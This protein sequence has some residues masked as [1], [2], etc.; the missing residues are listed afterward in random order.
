MTDENGGLEVLNQDQETKD[1]IAE[2]LK[3]HH[4]VVT[5]PIDE[6]AIRER[7]ELERKAGA[8][9]A[10]EKSLWEPR[11]ALAWIVFGDPAAMNDNYLDELPLLKLCDMPKSDPRSVPSRI[12]H[13]RPGNALFEAVCSGKV[14]AIGPDGRDVPPERWLFEP[15]GWARNDDYRT[16]EDLQFRQEEMLSE[17]PADVSAPAHKATPAKRPAVQKYPPMSA[18]HVRKK[19]PSY[20]EGR[21][22]E[23]LRDHLT[24]N[25]NDEHKKAES[26]FESTISRSEFRK[27]F[28]ETG[29]G[30]RGPKPRR[31]EP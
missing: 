28:N 4:D 20:L 5:A 13:N 12:K 24:F 7:L 25:S 22:A 16:W 23:A 3:A 29:G 10:Y 11:E 31:K 8:A 27:H 26:H 18:A 15:G 30:V 17:F 21:R 14:K 2:R 6:N 9:K 1:R 19:L